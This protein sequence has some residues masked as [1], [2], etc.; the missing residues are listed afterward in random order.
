MGQ[1]VHGEIIVACG[2]CG[3]RSGEGSNVRRHLK[4]SVCA[5]DRGYSKK[6]LDGLNRVERQKFIRRVAS[7]KFRAKKKLEGT[8]KTGL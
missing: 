5:R 8:I 2:R 6:E 3:Y 1:E 4:N 7:A